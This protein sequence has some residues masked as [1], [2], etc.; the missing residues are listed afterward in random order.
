MRLSSLNF[1]AILLISAAVN[2]NFLGPRFSPPTHFT[3]DSL[4]AASWKNLGSNLDAYLQGNRQGV[5]S[6]LLEGLENLTFSL[7]MFS[8]HDPAAETLQY[9]YTSKE[10]ANGKGAKEVD[11][12]SIYRVASV[13]KL[14]SV[15]AGML[16]FSDEQWNQPITDFVPRLSKSTLDKITT[17]SIHYIQWEDVT[18]RAL[19]SQIAGIPRDAQPVLSDIALDPVTYLGVPDPTS[20][21]LPPLDLVNDPSTIAPCLIVSDP[22]NDCTA[23]LYFEGTEQRLPVFQSWTTPAYTN[24]GFILLGIALANITGKP[25]AQVYPDTIFDPLGMKDSRSNPPESEWSQYVIPAGGEAGWSAPGG[26]SI[27]S[28]GL[29]SSL[30]DMAKFGTAILNHTLLPEHKTRQWLKPISHSAQFEFSV[31]TPWEIYRYKHADTGAITDIYTKLGDSGNYTGFVCLVPDYDAGFTVLSAG[32]NVTQKSVLASTIADL[33]TTTILPALEAQAAMETENNFAGIYTSTISG[34]NS[35]ITISY[36]DTPAA[37]GLYITSWIS[38]NTN[39]LPLLPFLTG[40]PLKLQPSLSQPGQSAF[41]ARP[42]AVPGAYLGPFGRMREVDGDWLFGEGL[43]YGAVGLGQV[44]FD[45]DGGGWA[46]G[47]ELLA[48]RSFL[49]RVG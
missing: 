45:V 34:L 2:A 41:L 49:E 31:G 10:V 6:S 22:V 3:G 35:S 7:G 4:V 43:T 39:L 5:E 36:N 29:L 28:G 48:F 47:V 46:R 25:I 27:S 15:Y 20:L 8:V 9:H 13:S 26:I 19:A 30:N 40:S 44:V 18:L 16:V 24:N 21:G 42:V 17:D 12:N 1:I 23:D 32:S 33:I 37:P 14:F 38:N 11:G